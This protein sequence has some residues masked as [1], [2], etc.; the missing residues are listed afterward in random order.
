MQMGIRWDRV[1]VANKIIS[2]GKVDLIGNKGGRESHR[3]QAFLG[4]CVSSLRGLG[5]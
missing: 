3:K 2:S 1:M 4:S 5:G